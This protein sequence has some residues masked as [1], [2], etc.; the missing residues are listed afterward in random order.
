MVPFSAFGECSQALPRPSYRGAS[1]DGRAGVNA[2]ENECSAA[3]HDLCSLTQRTIQLAEL[4]R[5]LPHLHEQV[6]LGGLHVFDGRR[7]E[8]LSNCSNDGAL[9]QLSR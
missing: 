9:P 6:V 2:A 3:A 4:R 1:W 7:E 5:N 8:A